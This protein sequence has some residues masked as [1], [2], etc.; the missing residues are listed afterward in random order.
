MIDNYVFDKAY[1]LYLKSIKSNKE[2]NMIIDNIH[3]IIKSNEYIELLK[4]YKEYVKNISNL[5]LKLNIDNPL[6]I[7]LLYNDLLFD[8]YFS[9][10]KQFDIIDTTKLDLLVRTWGSRVCTGKSVCRH[11][12]ALLVDIERNL[13]NISEYVDMICVNKHNIIKN[14]LIDNQIVTSPNHLVVGLQSDD[15]VYLYDPNNYYF[16]FKDNFN[17]SNNGVIRY[18]G[19]EKSLKYF[20]KTITNFNI[21]VND[22]KINYDNV[23][24]FSKIDGDYITEISDK[25][26]RI[27]SLKESLINNFYMDNSKKV[28]KIAYLN[29]EIILKQKLYK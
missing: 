26:T 23:S 11:N 10:D 12:A 20:D 8:G 4:E 1:L 24:L 18:V 21:N 17:N 22:N 27:Y 25:V 14:K 2:Y 3:K 5:F 15:K 28:R 13:G 29:N 7:A 6:E 16:L 9:C 19:I